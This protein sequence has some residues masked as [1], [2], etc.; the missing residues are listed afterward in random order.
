MSHRSNPDPLDFLD[1][2]VIVAPIIPTS[3]TAANNKAR[4][5]ARVIYGARL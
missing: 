2:H 1:A 5:R 3:A 4:C